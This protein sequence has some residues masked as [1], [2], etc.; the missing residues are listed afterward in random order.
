MRSWLDAAFNFYRGGFEIWETA[1]GGHLNYPSTKST[2]LFVEYSTE[3]Q[4]P[5]AD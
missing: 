2:F 1:I 3:H 5:F 4:R